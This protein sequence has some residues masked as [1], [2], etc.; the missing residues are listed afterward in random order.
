MLLDFGPYLETNYLETKRHVIIL[1]RL[2][3][4][5]VHL[6]SSAIRI[7]KFYTWVNQNI[8]EQI[9]NGK[10][11]EYDAE[12]WK[13]LWNV[14]YCTFGGYT[15]LKYKLCRYW[16]KG[17]SWYR[18]I[19]SMDR[20][21]GTLSRMLFKSG[22]NVGQFCCGKIRVLVGFRCKTCIGYQRSAWIRYNMSVF[23]VQ[24]STGLCCMYS[25]KCIKVQVPG[26]RYLIYSCLTTMLS[27]CLIHLVL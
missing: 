13:C 21:F 15:D 3:L 7:K 16:L 26:C 22:Y 19:N 17:G 4:F 23:A 12:F 6:I 1:Q 25:Y 18:H 27:T 10:H 8:C 9:F 5:Y 24:Y 2:M 14:V 11:D 20:K